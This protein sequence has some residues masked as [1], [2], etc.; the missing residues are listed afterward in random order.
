MGPTKSLFKAF[1]VI[2]PIT[3]AS[4]KQFISLCNKPEF[5]RIN[6]DFKQF[7][8]NKSSFLFMTRAEPE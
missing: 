8:L 7:K 2:L 6:V 5:Y 3:I 4:P 1:K